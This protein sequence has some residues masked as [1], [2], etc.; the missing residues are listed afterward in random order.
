MYLAFLDCSKAFDRISHWGLFVKLIKRQVPLCFLLSVLY[1]YLNMSCT[2]KWKTSLSKVFD[3]PTGTKQGGILSPS[4]FAMYMHDLIEKLKVSGYG[5][6]VIQM[7]IA[8]I[9]FADDIVLLSP[10]R[11]GLQ[12]LLNICVTYCSKFCL[13]FNVKKSKVM[14]A[15][16]N[17]HEDV[18]PLNLGGASLDFVSSFKYLGVHLQ[19]NKIGLS[20]SSTTVIR[21]FHRAANSILN[22]RVKPHSS[23]LMRLLY[24]NCVPILTY[25]C[26]VKEFSVSEMYRCHVAVNNAIRK[27]FS[28][29][30]WQSI[31][32]LRMSH[33][34]D[35]V[36]EIF[37]KAKSKFMASAT[38][39][40]NSII[41]HLSML[42]TSQNS[43]NV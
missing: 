29:A 18:L 23:V 33:G 42:A 20:F 6:Y 27:I 22:G 16:C 13:D 39:S 41:T 37:A 4:F 26:A 15:G 43:V 2:V 25:A 35:S 34:Y 31:R 36:Y 28:Y 19:A 24:S 12:Q 5:T 21:S 40:S 32:H 11:H 7:C 9:F 17:S 14:I 3:V 38:R 30:V 10:S 1:L 8:C